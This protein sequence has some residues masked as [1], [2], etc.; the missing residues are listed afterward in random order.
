MAAPSDILSRLRDAGILAA[1]ERAQVRRL[2]GGVS[3]DVYRLETSAGVMCVKAAL[4][5]LRVAA[6][7]R[8]PVE[9][10]HAEVAWLQTVRPLVGEA[11]PEVLAEAREQHLFVMTYLEPERHL[12]WKSEL[13]AGRVE[14]AFA[15]EVGALLGRI[16]AGARGPDIAA[17]FETG[18][19]FEALRLSPYLRHAAAAHPDLRNVLL[20]LADRTAATRLALVHGDVSPMRAGAAGRRVRLVRRP[21]VRSRILRHPSAAEGR[22]EAGSRRRLR[23]RARRVWRRLSA[24]GGLGISG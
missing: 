22:L 7:W 1:G 16:H 15:A 20:S 13:A 6:E 23:R 21:G 4:P 5:V 12:V 18:A 24:A 9:R 17:R 19:L 3:S 8:A 10:S 11:V 2:T 14:A